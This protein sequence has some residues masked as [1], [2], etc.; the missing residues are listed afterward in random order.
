[1]SLVDTNRLVRDY[2]TTSSVLTDPLLI[3]IGGIATPRIYCPRLEENATLPA[4]SFLTRGGR[5]DPSIVKLVSPS[6]QFDCWADNPIDARGI[7]RALYDAMA[8]LVSVSIVIDGTT[9]YITKIYEEVQG[10]DLIDTE[11]PYYFRVLTFYSI[12]IREV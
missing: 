5:A 6:V 11:I 4:V 10:Q 3:L 8:G 2:L 12:T 1:M 9:Y 7:Y